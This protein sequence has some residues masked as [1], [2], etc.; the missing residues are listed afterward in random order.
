MDKGVAVVAIN[1]DNP[2]AVRLS[3][4]GYSDVG[5]SLPEMKARA[6]HRRFEYPYLY[7]GDTQAVVAEVR[8]RRD[9][10]HFRVR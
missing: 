1:P 6:T 7:D 3:D 2:A 10:A 4:L 9:A 5:D 8:G